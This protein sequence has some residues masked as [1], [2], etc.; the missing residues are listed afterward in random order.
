MSPL[1][2]FGQWTCKVVVWQTKSKIDLVRLL[3][4]LKDKRY[5]GGKVGWQKTKYTATQCISCMN[6][7]PSHNNQMHIDFDINVLSA[8]SNLYTNRSFTVEL[9]INN[10]SHSLLYSLQSSHGQYTS[11]WGLRRE[12]LKKFSLD[13]LA[14]LGRLRYS[15]LRFGLASAGY[16]R[17]VVHNC[18]ARRT[19]PVNSQ[20]TPQS[21]MKN[22]GLVRLA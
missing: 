6:C 5:N 17:L 16:P 8:R 1:S 18:M 11:C 3:T 2:W 20:L 12:F 4:Q 14:K 22:L 7:I 10:A 21:S 19:Q 13:G 9:G 15:C